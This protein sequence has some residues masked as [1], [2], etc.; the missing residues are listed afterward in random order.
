MNTINEHQNTQPSVQ[1]Y[2]NTQAIISIEEEFDE[3]QLETP[4]EIFS[5][6]MDNWNAIN[7][8]AS[9]V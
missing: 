1:E 6:E 7:F 4:W 2:L 5:S 8:H 3:V 9:D